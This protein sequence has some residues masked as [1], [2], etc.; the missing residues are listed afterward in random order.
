MKISF[1]PF[2]VTHQQTNWAV[3]IVVGC[4]FSQISMF[5]GFS[6][7]FIILFNIQV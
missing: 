6:K 3:E 7:N 5:V 1:S 2:P 4:L